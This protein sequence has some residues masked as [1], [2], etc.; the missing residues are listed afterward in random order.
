MSRRSLL[1]VCLIAGAMLF[2]AMPVFALDKLV[3]F[4]DINIQVSY[5]DWPDIM[6]T[7]PPGVG[8]EK[9]VSNGDCSF[10]L[11]AVPLDNGTFRNFVNRVI[12]EQA[13]QM[14]VKLTSKVITG[15]FYDIAS[16]I[17]I[18]NQSVRQYVHGLITPANVIYQATIT[19]AAE[20]FNKVCLPYVK[21]SIKSI[22]NIKPKLSEPAIPKDFR[23]YIYNLNIGSKPVGE[24]NLNKFFR[25]NILEANAALCLKGKVIK[26]IP[27]GAVSYSIYSVGNSANIREELM[28][29]LSKKGNFTNCSMENLPAG[30]YEYKILMDG[31]VGAIYPFI[32]RGEVVQKNIETDI[33]GETLLR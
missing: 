21:T 1:V 26:T 20:N 2:T 29:G 4:K 5:P 28:P 15:T 11:S 18:G 31:V 12:K 25:T 23:K 3:V 6:N 8:I 24:N 19:G 14:N 27:E 32:V 22:K 30:Q 33:I 7:M 17:K 13:K 10:I 9:A 16:T